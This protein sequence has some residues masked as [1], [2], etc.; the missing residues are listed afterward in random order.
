MKTK[1]NYYIDM[2]GTIADFN[3]EPD[4]VKRFKHERGFFNNL[5]PL[6]KN[7]QAVKKL[8]R[9]GNN[10][11][12]ITA[13][14]NEKADGDKLNWLRK[15][16]PEICAENIIIT[17]LKENKAQAMKTADGILFDDYSKNCNEWVSFNDVNRAVKIKADGDIAEGIKA[18]LALKDRVL[19]N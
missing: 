19:N 17:R 10:V 3:G 1:L 6:K 18:V 16:L 7:L 14:P 4:G 9:D 11:F 15:Y 8:A 2:D 12:I 5:K 13:S